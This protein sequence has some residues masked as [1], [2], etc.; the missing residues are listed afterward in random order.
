MTLLEKVLIV[1]LCVQGLFLGWAIVLLG[2]RDRA[3]RPQGWPTPPAKRKVLSAG[4]MEVVG[5]GEGTPRYTKEQIA[6]NLRQRHS[7]SPEQ[8][9]AAAA[10]ILAKA[11]QVLPRE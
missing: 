6:R 2:Q 4:G 11:S 9:E 1:A 3:R 7:I 10:E 5:E 8:A